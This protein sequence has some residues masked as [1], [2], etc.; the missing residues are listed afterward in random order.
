MRHKNITFAKKKKATQI[1]FETT[2]TRFEFFVFRIN[3]KK[4]PDA[5]CICV[6]CVTSPAQDPCPCR[7]LFDYRC[8]IWNIPNSLGNV[9]ETFLH[10]GFFTSET[11]IW[12]RILGNE[13]WAPECWT[14]ILGSNF[15]TLFFPAK[16]APWKI[17]PREIHLPKSTFQNS[18]QKSGQKNSHCT[19]A[20]R[21]GWGNVFCGKW[22]AK[23][24]IQENGL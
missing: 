14:R 7:I 5:L 1:I 11:R 3:F 17:H 18:T 22:E 10:R 23:K 12:G 19:S 21:F 13:F 2:A 9:R 16:E 8:P 24:R 20:G 6:S 4:L 15:L